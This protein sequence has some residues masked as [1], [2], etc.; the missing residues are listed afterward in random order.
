[1]KEKRILGVDPGTNILG[2]AFIKIVDKEIILESMGVVWLKKYDDPY[3]KLQKIQERLQ[4][5]ITMFQPHEMG[6]EAP[7]YGKNVQSMLKLG[8]AQGVVIATAMTLGVAVTE[9]SAKKIKQSI[10]GNGNASK[11]Q[12]A[13]MVMRMLKIK[14]LPQYSDTTDALGVAI[15]HYLQTQNKLKIGDGQFKD[16]KAFANSNPDKV[17]K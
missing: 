1:M 6:I 16:W 5:M 8:R 17:K 11:E 14:E 7:F 13:A 12:V 2:Y 9:Y 15:C 10:T 4:A 3:T